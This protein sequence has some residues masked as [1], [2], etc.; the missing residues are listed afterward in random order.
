MQ[1]IYKIRL[2][3]PELLTDGPTAQ[4]AE[5]LQG[6][7]AYL[8]AL[9]AEDKVLLAGRTQIEDAEAFGIV[10]LSVTSEQEAETIMNN[11]PAVLHGVMNASLFPYQIAFM[12]PNIAAHAGGIHD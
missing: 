6:H 9:A 8:A 5:A 2:V 11:D 1:Y 3:R 7:A 4:E 10:I 12:S